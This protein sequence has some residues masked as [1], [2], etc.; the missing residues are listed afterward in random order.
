MT[1]KLRGESEL[2]EVSFRSRSAQTAADVSNAVVNAYL[3]LAQEQA[4]TQSE[5]IISL[6]K[7]EKSQR[8][9]DIEGH[10][11]RIR[12]LMKKSQG[13]DPA[14]AGLGKRNRNIVVAQDPV[15]ELEAR[16]TAAEIER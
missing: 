9:K 5:T 15:A 8:A 2:C 14:L 10:Q 11:Q 4:S 12:V 3:S 7:D 13:H 1:V 16:R 6:L